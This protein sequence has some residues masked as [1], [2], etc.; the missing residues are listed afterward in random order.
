[1]PEAIDGIYY[2]NNLNKVNAEADTWCIAVEMSINLQ[3]LNTWNNRR[4][5]LAI[6]EVSW[7]RQPAA[8]PFGFLSC[9]EFAVP[10]QDNYDSFTHLSLADIAIDRRFSPETVQ[11]HIKQSKTDAFQQGANICLRKTDEEACPVRAIVASLAIRS[12]KPRPL[13]ILPD[14]RWLTYIIFGLAIANFLSGMQ[15]DK[16]SYE[17]HIASK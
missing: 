17:T 16:G 10:Q 8:W 1:M 12:N 5:L 2:Y 13:F 3:E 4:H 11:V 14:G 9:S 15:M 7:F 6:N